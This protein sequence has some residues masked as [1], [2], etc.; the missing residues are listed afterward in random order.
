MPFPTVP[1]LNP[2]LL[3]AL[4]QQKGIAAGQGAPGGLGSAAPGG[5]GAGLPGAGGAAGPQIGPGAFGP[6]GTAPPMPAQ[7]PMMQPP[8]PGFGALTGQGAPLNPMAMMQMIQAM[9]ARGL[10]PGMS[11]AGGAQMPQ[12]PGGGL[13]TPDNQSWL[14]G[15]NAMAGRGGGGGY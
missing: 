5:V 13:L 6:A 7:P 12:Q 9:K 3:A 10:Q 2:L 15:L 4:M 11:S 14:Q 1:Q 8:N